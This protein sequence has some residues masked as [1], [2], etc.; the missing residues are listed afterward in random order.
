VYRGIRN[1][2][3]T[4]TTLLVG[5]VW[6]MG[7]MTLTVGH[8]N[9]LSATFAVML[10]G[11][12]D[13]GVLWVTRYEE[14]RNAGHGVRS[15][16]RR[17]A[18]GGGPSILTAATATAFAFFAAMLAD[19][20]AV[21][22]LGWIA[23]SGVLMCALS[24]F[25]VLP[26][27]LCLCDRRSS[28][29]AKRESGSRHILSIEERRPRIENRGW[30]PVLSRRPRWVIAGGLGLTALLAFQALRVKYDHNLLH[31]QAQD[32]SSVQWEMTL[33][34]HTE[35]AS[36]HAL[37]LAAD[38]AEALRMK[39]RF[40]K[41]P[42]VSRVVEVAS[43]VPP[44]Q[45]RKLVQLRDIQ[46]RLQSLPE[47]GEVIP[48]SPPV[49]AGLKAKLGLLA[50]KLPASANGG[51]QRVVRDLRQSLIALDR[52]LGGMSEPLAAARL[53]T[54]EERLTADLLENLRQLRD[55]ST[56]AAITLDDLPAQMRERY[57]GKNGKWLLQVFARDCLWDHAPL[58]AFVDKVRAVDPGATGKPFG[59]LYGLKSLKS[60]F[61]WAGLYALLAIVLVFL[62]DF[63]HFRHTLLALAP[64][65]MG[66]VISLGVMG[67]LGLSLNPANMIAF[68][69]ILGVGAVYG[70][71]VVHDYLVQ[72]A[73]PRYT[74][75]YIIGRAILVMALTNM[76]GFGTLAISSHRGLSSLG[77]TLMLGVCC[78]M[79]T[80]LVFL[81][82]VL[83]VLSEGK[84]AM[85][86]S[87]VKPQKARIAA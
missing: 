64:L 37:S 54:F 51:A 2:F 43:L 82:A 44:D 31:L 14:N 39:A 12:G 55:A 71:H 29:V 41:L 62:A 68:P 16:L 85:T 66:V 77:F 65:V 25:T 80:A 60:G 35:G 76:I 74:L 50:R 27:M 6:A 32:L 38:P 83:R 23:G 33:V 72:G 48:H 8:L 81:P 19:F 69:L 86:P 13:Y 57:I 47:R 67:L 11:M 75:S 78:C 58:Q 17:T 22:E 21:A 45:D 5:T 7:W 84:M 53:K 4:V 56:P 40:E 34:K 18:A 42:E 61:Q 87:E 73:A 1:P 24:C 28:F 30:L 70:V 36:W 49:V 79:V 59:T 52:K 9:I 10:I 26:A 46:T 15:A 20:Q 63:R 3:L